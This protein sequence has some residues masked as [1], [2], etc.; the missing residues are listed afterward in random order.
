[1]RRHAADGAPGAQP[2]G[3]RTGTAARHGGRRALRAVCAANARLG[4]DRHQPDSRSAWAAGDLDGGPPGDRF[5]DR[6]RERAGAR[7][8]AW[9]AGVLSGVRLCAAGA[10]VSRGAARP[11]AAGPASRA[12]RDPVIAATCPDWTAAAGGRRPAR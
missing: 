12:A 4:S 2:T 3:W 11:D 9:L 8:A 10:L 5:R 1:D 6:P 7:R